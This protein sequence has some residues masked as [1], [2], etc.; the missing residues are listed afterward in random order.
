MTDAILPARLRMTQNAPFLDGLLARYD[1]TD[2]AL[3]ESGISVG[4]RLRLERRQVALAVAEGDVVQEGDL[5]A[6][7]D[8]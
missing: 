3:A 4:K 8:G 7:I 6:V 2:A 5:I 1:V